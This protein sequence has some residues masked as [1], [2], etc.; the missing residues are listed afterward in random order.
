M[1]STS[2]V[3]RARVDSA[4][5]STAGE[6]T[7]STLTVRLFAA[8]AEAAGAETLHLPLE[9]P[10]ALGTVLDGL[11]ASASSGDGEQLG[12]VLRRC[13]F[14]VNGVRAPSNDREL[15]PGDQLDVLPPFAGG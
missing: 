10:A 2:P 4:E 11:P 3:S 14:L 5:E 15:A 6:R 13:S 1:T 8:A 12:R 9:Q 7:A